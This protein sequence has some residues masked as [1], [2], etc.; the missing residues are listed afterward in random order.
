[1]KR[2]FAWGKPRTDE[3]L[4]ARLQALPAA[5]ELSQQP[6]SQQQWVVLDVE[7]TGLNL[8]RDL[9]LSIGAVAI[10]GNSIGLADGF[11]CTLNRDQQHLG[12][13]VLLHGISPSELAAGL[14]PAE[15]LL[16]FMEYLGDRP[17]LAF[18]A[19]FDQQ[20]LARA[21]KEEF[22]YKLRH[23]FLDL[24]DL[25]PMLCPQAGLSK[26]GL[27]DWMSFFGLANLQRHNA[28]ADALATAELALILFSRARRQG[29]DSAYALSDALARWK[30][31]QQQSAW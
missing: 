16:A 22:N 11:T 5:A 30:R 1:M 2:L 17:L 12:D 18:H 19:P 14:T 24:A 20:M 10:E 7:S 23:P 21:L 26:G 27:D 29:L 28:Y 4:H 6:L 8:Q 15:A 3:V 13:S 9:L 31:R 25:A